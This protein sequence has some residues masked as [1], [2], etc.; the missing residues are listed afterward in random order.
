MRGWLQDETL[1]RVLRNTGLLGSGKVAGALIH[2]VGL[3]L[4]ARLLGP[5][6]FGLLVLI[7]S[8][9]Q[10]TSGIAKF[11]SWQALIH[12]G[13]SAL[14][15]EE[16]GRFADLFAFVIALDLVTGLAAMLAGILLL[17]AIGPWFGLSEPQIPV[18][19][20]YCLAIPLMTAAAPT[21]LLRLFDRFDHLSIQALVTPLVRLA[22]LALAW[23]AGAPFWAVV[24]AWLVSDLIGDLY[25]WFAA[26][27]ESRRNRIFEGLRPAPRRGWHGHKGMGRFI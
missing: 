2:L 17:P 11:Q 22:A 15:R 24:L 9:A 3:A 4:T 6:P 1:A 7:R 8:F 18:A 14:R 21:G 19:Q 26:W 12:Y 10:G 16:R 13:G 23:A 20:L 5:V 25:L 27:R